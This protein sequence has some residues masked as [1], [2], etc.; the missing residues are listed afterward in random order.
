MLTLTLGS[1]NR[2]SVLTVSYNST[3]DLILA[4][5]WL[6][7]VCGVVKMAVKSGVHQAAVPRL[8]SLSRDRSNGSNADEEEE[9]KVGACHLRL[10]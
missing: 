8:L 2:L 7:I 4:L 10:R 9:W 3:Q 1:R 5:L 6:P